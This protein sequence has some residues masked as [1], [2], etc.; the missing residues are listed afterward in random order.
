MRVRGAGREKGEE[1]KRQGHR[2][3]GEPFLEP[4]LL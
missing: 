1:E 2:G 4:P 3:K